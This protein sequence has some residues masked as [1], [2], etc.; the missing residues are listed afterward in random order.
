MSAANYTG[1]LPSVIRL[2]MR[3][4]IRDWRAGE[5]RVLTVA[6]VIAVTCVTSVV[7]FTDRIRQALD[8]QASELLAADI[9]LNSSR[10]VDKKFFAKA[11]ESG[12]QTSQTISFRSMSV[13]GSAYQLSEIKAVDEN[14]PLRGQL[15]TSTEPFGVGVVNSEVPATGTLWIDPRLMSQLNVRLNDSITL[16]NR[17]FTVSQFLLYEPDRSGDLFSIA[18]RIL[19]NLADLPATGLIQEGSRL[20]YR[21]LLAGERS[22]IVS[23]R[24]WA[25][26]QLD[27][28]EKIEDIRDARQEIR[29]ALERG[30]QFLGLSAIVSVIL[31]CIAVAMSARRYAARHMDACAVMRCVGAKQSQISRLF[32]SQ[33][34]IIGLV[35]SIVGCGLGFVAHLGIYQ[36]ASSLFVVNLPPVSFWPVVSGVV[37]CLIGLLGFAL[38]AI[39]RL[40]NVSTLQVL[41]KEYGKLPPQVLSSYGIGILLLALLV[42]WQAQSIRLGL[43]VLAG[44]CLAA[45]L[46]ATCAWLLI[47]ILKKFVSERSVNWRLSVTHIIRRKGTSVAQILAFGVGIMVL[48]L[49]GFVRTDLLASWQDSLPADASNR[50]VI[51]I[52]KDQ[53]QE[54][55]DFFTEYGLHQAKLYPMVRGRLVKINGNPINTDHLDSDRA[56]RLA[57]R[58]YN[59]SWA[60]TLQEDNKIVQGKWWGA[61]VKPT[62]QFSVEQGLAASL[63]LQLG[64]TLSYDIAGEQ[65]TAPVTS[66]RAV[67]WDTFRANFFVLASPGLLDQLPASYITSFYLP[68]GKAAILDELVRKFPNLTV[69]DISVI[70][71]QVR[72]IISRI[73]LAVE[74]VFLFTL[75]AGLTVLY[76]AIQTTLDERIR[77]NAILRAVGAGRR[78]LMRGN[79]GEFVILGGLSGLLAA[80]CASIAGY[81]L[82]TQVFDLAFHLNPWIWLVG[83]LGGAT[84][85]GVAGL[86][87]T[88][89]VLISPPLS[90]IK[91][92]T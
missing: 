8:Y 37:V 87:G 42:L 30:Q 33:L 68:P 3:F 23:Y 57:T 45:V 48:L 66:L 59:L 38:P 78:R 62:P 17:S 72:T 35:A 21:L 64:D 31:S 7:F 52:Q 50:F 85:V 58:D 90:I 74:G 41:R 10:P 88:R 12:L 11:K 84:G 22:S 49:L 69:V 53:L 34:L 43:M 27:N 60:L 63:N 4:L 1:K 75:L 91:T 71:Q 79:I 61:A 18:P 13:S 24:Q 82:A 65:I 15:K 36:V 2:A 80:L 5:I 9:R 55:N 6:L 54:I 25:D 77:E 14:Y 40:K 67:R 56:K 28:G 86:L 29:S 46:L 92:N 83:L 73:T 81:V 19:M 39:N 20:R 16:G 89:R 51:N 32:M 44:V 26:Q 76:A 70:M 47:I